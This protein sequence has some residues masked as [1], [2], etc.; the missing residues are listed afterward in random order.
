MADTKETSAPKKASDARVFDVA[1]PGKSA[2]T[3]T[4]KPVIVSNR[5]I[6]QDPMVIQ[7]ASTTPLSDPNPADNV[8]AKAT[9]ERVITPLKIT[10][11][12]DNEDEKAE[13][14]DDKKDKVV[15]ITDSVESAAEVPKLPVEADATSDEEQDL[16]EVALGEAVG[17]PEL[18]KKKKQVGPA[19][20]LIADVM[21]KAA[22]KQEFAASEAA[23]ESDEVVESA[24]EAAPIAETEAPADHPTD[25]ASTKSK[26]DTDTTEP[27]A[28]RP[29][30]TDDAAVSEEGK[31]AE[32]AEAASTE[33]EASDS[34]GDDSQPT[35]DGDQPT[36]TNE[37]EQKQKAAEAAAKQHEE[38]EQKLIDS[39]QY[40]L[41]INAVERRKTKRHLLVALLII[42]VVAIAW[43]DLALDAG[44]LHV[45][46]VD[47]PTHFFKNSSL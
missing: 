37:E 24:A 27:P 22:L 28:E 4:S 26:T 10:F 6:L 39:Q 46:G 5:P 19:G 34:I 41:P 7:N 1:K 21:R 40:F 44:I 43:G 29:P 47:A 23:K 36:L 9:R 3:A 15:V 38:E 13:K 30:A 12:D 42:V 2:A 16:G 33:P 35:A 32:P 31:S 11:K 45:K 18:P 20:P 25:D 14:K 8:P 17:P